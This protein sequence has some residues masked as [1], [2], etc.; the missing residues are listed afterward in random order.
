MPVKALD[1]FQAYGQNK[2]P[3]EGGYIVSSF[4][5]EQ[6]SYSTYEVVAYNG[7]KALYLS[8]EGLTFQTDGNKLYVLAEPAA[9]TNKH[10]EP[11][12]RE[13]RF[14]VPH[15]F[16]EMEL[17]TARN[18]T[19][20]MVSKEPI[21]AYSSFTILRPTGINFAFFFFNLPDVLDSIAVFFEKT[22]N[23]E[24]AVPQTDARKAAGL[25]TRGLQ[26]FTIWKD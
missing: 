16:S 5:Q 3:A 2:L 10:E 21:L 24:A 14:Q 4:F 22:L 1:L 7:V 26:R 9:Y 23:R 25:I 8:E 17:V 19:R 13:K 15:R 11:F 20:V 18:Q 12:R 6:S